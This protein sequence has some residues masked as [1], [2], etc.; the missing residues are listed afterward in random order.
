MDVPCLQKNLVP[1]SPLQEGQ[2]GQAASLTSAPLQRV[3]ASTRNRTLL[4]AITG[5]NHVGGEVVAFPTNASYCTATRE[6]AENMFSWGMGYYSGITGALGIMLFTFR[7]FKM[8][9]YCLHVYVALP[10]SFF[11][12]W[13]HFWPLQRFSS[14]S[15]FRW[16]L[17]SFSSWS[18]VNQV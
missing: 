2:R 11:F 4:P 16:C 15:C 18:I 5:Q 10:Y 6:Q 13:S 7:P 8:L 17:R 9:L 12:F 14:S 1:S 3:Q